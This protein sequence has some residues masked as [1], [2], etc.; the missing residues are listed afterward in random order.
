MREIVKT[1]CHCRRMSLWGYFKRKGPL[2]D[3]KGS[4]ARIIPSSAIAAANSE[5]EKSYYRTRCWY[6]TGAMALDYGLA[7]WTA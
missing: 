6:Y 7:S 2:L 4:L 3:P 5:V 1:A